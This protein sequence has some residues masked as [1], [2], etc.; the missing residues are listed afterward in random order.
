MVVVGEMLMEVGVETSGEGMAVEIGQDAKRITAEHT[1][2]M[3]ERTRHLQEHMETDLA[4]DLIQALGSI[5]AH[6]VTPGVQ[7]Q[8]GELIAMAR[9]VL[10]LESL[11]LLLL[12]DLLF[13]SNRPRLHKLP[14]LISVHRQERPGREHLTILDDHPLL[15]LLALLFDINRLRLHKLVDPI[16]V[17]HHKHLTI[18]DREEEAIASHPVIQLR[19]ILVYDQSPSKDVKLRHQDAQSIRMLLVMMHSRPLLRRQHLLAHLRPRKKHLTIQARGGEVIVLHLVTQ[20]RRILVYDQ[21][22]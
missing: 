6:G 8:R 14:D 18:L 5:G 13:N 11:P 3:A 4:E 22:P 17:P 7:V 21:S 9:E 16:K 15:L 19:K 20:L 2:N 12:N 1:E 10:P